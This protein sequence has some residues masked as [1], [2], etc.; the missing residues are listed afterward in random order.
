MQRFA[1]ILFL[2]LLNTSISAQQYKK[3]VLTKDKLTIDL[4]EG[5]L[6]IIPLT[7]KSIR[8][9]Y[10]IENTK[11]AQEFVLINKHNVPGFTLKESASSLKLFTKAITVT[12][13]K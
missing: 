6:K 4:S 8:V 1:Y 12:F 9:Q 10:Q 3:H 7:D 11:E 13:D 2:G 5:V